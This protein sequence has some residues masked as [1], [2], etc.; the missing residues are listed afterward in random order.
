MSPAPVIV[1]STQGIPE[2]DNVYEGDIANTKTKYH[3]WKTIVYMVQNKKG[4]RRERELVNLIHETEFVVMRAPASGAATT[5][6]LPDVLAG[7]GEDFYAVE[8]KSSNG[9]PIY[10][11]GEEIDALRKFAKAF[12]AKPRIGVKFDL[13]YGDPAYGED[14]LPGWY[15]FTPDDLH[16]TDGGNYRVKKETALDD[17]VR[18]RDMFGF[19]VEDEPSDEETQP[20]Q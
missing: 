12:G 14:Q 11:G 17:G 3:V 9:D 5:R 2:V 10:I 20:T 4:S 18:F 16:V 19:P 7:D 1:V 6:E 8:A 13:E 15:F